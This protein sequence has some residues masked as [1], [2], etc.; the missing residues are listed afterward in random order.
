[1]KELNGESLRL[2]R[3]HAGYTQQQLAEELGVRQQT[4][5]RWEKGLSGI[6]PYNIRLLQ[7][8]CQKNG[9]VLESLIIEK[10]DA[11]PAPSAGKSTFSDSISLSQAMPSGI[12]ESPPA[13]YTL[14]QNI[15]PVK[16]I[17]I[18]R[19]DLLLAIDDKLS[20]NRIL[21]LEGIG[22]IGKTELA[23]HYAWQHRDRYE[24]I[25]FCT[26]SQ[27]LLDMVCDPQKIE[28]TGLSM[29]QDESRPAFFSRKMGILRAL[30]SER[31]LLI[32][33]NYDVEGDP[34]F[35]EFIRGSH[36]IIFTSRKR[37]RTYSW[38]SVERIDRDEELLQLFSL[39]SEQRL[40]KAD[41]PDILEL[42]S[43]TGF[44]TYA[45][46][47]LAKQLR[48]SNLSVHQL[49]LRLKQ[50]GLAHGPEELIPGRY[51]FEKKRT[52]FEH[53]KS[54]FSIDTMSEEEKQILRELSIVGYDGIPTAVYKI[55]GRL[56]DYNSLNG[57]IER[58]WI[59]EKQGDDGERLCMLHPLI[60]EVMRDVLSPTPETCASFIHEM[61]T[62]LEHTWLRPYTD[63]L[64]VKNAVIA[65]TE[66][67][68]P[69]RP[70][71]SACVAAVDFFWQIGEFDRAISYG[72]NVF[73]ACQTIYGE[74][75]LQTSTAACFL[76]ASYYNAGRLKESLPWYERAFACIQPFKDITAVEVALAYE[77]MGRC[78]TW[79]FNRNLDKAEALFAFSLSVRKSLIREIKAGKAS[80]TAFSREVYGLEKAFPALGCTYREIGLLR[81][82]QGDYRKAWNCAELFLLYIKKPDKIDPSGLAYG[83][84]DKG[85]C[86]YHM[87]IEKRREKNEEK[88]QKLLLRSYD[89]FSKAL[90]INLK[91]RNYYTLDTICNLEYLGD[92]CIALGH[93]EEAAKAY[94]EGIR[95]LSQLF[96]DNTEIKCRLERKVEQ[97]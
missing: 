44:H 51:A 87:G 12:S 13:T 76:A 30:T 73:N 7:K 15:P 42:L 89:E 21:F 43:M 8:F 60:A 2:Q 29:Q 92:A 77:K 67:F 57:L 27:S 97:L 88:A 96:R 61:G 58:S 59:Q 6:N 52:A 23:K 81:Q 18:G 39:Y 46:E 16:D 84:I 83:L 17:F 95:M 65:I 48:A 63:N 49:L 1:M 36:R 37:F 25:L 55:V 19:D 34:Q 4:I 38:L 56:S 71:M 66:Y 5:Q 41:K 9:W 50:N 3:I 79:D 33:D 20:A 11:I 90:E 40:T 22:A 24:S 53:I 28:I 74:N 80:T 31:T 94:E 70:I 62:Y 78:Y 72:I 85:I 93:T 82:L 54:I 91:M 64:K 69:S 10:G 86:N 75:S 26:F 45:A 32:V 47:L 68:K 35:S 14:V